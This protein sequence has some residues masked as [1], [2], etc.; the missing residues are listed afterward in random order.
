V[1]Q[2]QRAPFSKALSI[3]ASMSVL[4]KGG[5]ALYSRRLARGVCKRAIS[6]LSCSNEHLCKKGRDWIESRNWRDCETWIIYILKPITQLPFTHS[7][8][9]WFQHPVPAPS[10]TI[11]M[12]KKESKQFP[13]YHFSQPDPFLHQISH[14]QQTKNWPPLSTWQRLHGNN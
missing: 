3:W 10:T 6:V 2:S 5:D 8:I 9:S 14:R 1:T 4:M 13:A 11:W 12:Q 7:P